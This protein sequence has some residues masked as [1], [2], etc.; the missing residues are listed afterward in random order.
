MGEEED[1]DADEGDGDAEAKPINDNDARHPEFLARVSID[2]SGKRPAPCF[3]FAK[4]GR[5]PF[6]SCKYSHNLEDIRRDQEMLKNKSVVC[7]IVNKEIM[8][9]KILLVLLPSLRQ[10]LRELFREKNRAKRPFSEV[11]GL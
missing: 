5:Y 10:E 8:N 1:S 6:P 3:A 4:D 11:R 9:V 7:S 2:P